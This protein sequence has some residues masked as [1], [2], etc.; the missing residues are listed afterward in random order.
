MVTGASAGPIE[1]SSALTGG[2][3]EFASGAA[4]GW[5]VMTE[6]MAAGEGVLTMIGLAVI[7]DVGVDDGVSVLE[8]QA[9]RK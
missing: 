4:V 3:S 8:A 5:A 6:H 7:A 1:K 2:K 9:A